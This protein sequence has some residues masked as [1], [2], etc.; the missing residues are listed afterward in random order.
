MGTQHILRTAERRRKFFA[1]LL[2]A[3][4]ALIPFRMYAATTYTATWASVNKHTEAPE[5]FMDA[6]FGIYY[7]WGV[8]SVPAFGNEWY[9][10]NMYNR[11]GN[12]AEYQHQQ[13]G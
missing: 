6:K 9:P 8:Y 2:C 5:W 12:S 3:A 7:H 4:I 10:R 11:A 13:H 1:G